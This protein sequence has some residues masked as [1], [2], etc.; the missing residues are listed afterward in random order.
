MIVRIMGE[1]QWT[2]DPDVLLS[3]NE[4]DERVETAVA[5]G[6]DDELHAALSELLAA[7]REQGTEVPDD[8]IVES[9]L[10]LP[11]ADATVEEVTALLE[12]TQEF[13]GLLPDDRNGLP[14]RFNGTDDTAATEVAE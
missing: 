1:G 10:V 3:L 4:L 9:D 8:I 6:D 7:I 14:S 13:Y 12:G 2:V 11:A 5:R